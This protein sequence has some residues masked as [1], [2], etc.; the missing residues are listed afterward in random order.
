MSL[1]IDTFH[2]KVWKNLTTLPSAECRAVPVKSLQVLS[3]DQS[4][5]LSVSV[6]NLPESAVEMS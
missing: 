5:N 4:E 6:H 1:L 3:K 2:M